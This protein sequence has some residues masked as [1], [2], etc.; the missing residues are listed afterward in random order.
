LRAF[1]VENVA[2]RQIP[3]T[4]QEL[5]KAVQIL[6]PHSIHQVTETLEHLVEE[7]AAASPRS[8]SAKRVAACRRPG[9]STALDVSAGSRAIRTV[10]TQGHFTPLS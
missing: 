5:A 1:L 6:P 9:F 3:I 8:P 10:G 2:K 4:Y 7:D